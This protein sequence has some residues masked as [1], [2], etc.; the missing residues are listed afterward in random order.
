MGAYRAGFVAS[1]HVGIG[2]ISESRLGPENNITLNR[3]SDAP[4]A[5]NA[6]LETR[7]GVLR[8]LSFVHVS[9][10]SPMLTTKQP[11]F[12]FTGTHSLLTSISKPPPP[13]TALSFWSC[14]S[15]VNPV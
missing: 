1:T 5:F 12:G 4:G 14:R 15:I 9:H 6:G 8:H 11:L 13:S 2:P 10:R 3:D 7:C